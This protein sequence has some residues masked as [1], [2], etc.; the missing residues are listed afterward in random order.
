MRVRFQPLCEW[1][2]LRGVLRADGWTLGGGQKD[3]I[4]AAHR[5]VLDEAAARGRLHRLG[6]LTSSLLRIEFLLRP[7][8][9]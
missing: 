1:G 5:D 9:G 3:V 4:V 8:D 6:L 7:W 2:D